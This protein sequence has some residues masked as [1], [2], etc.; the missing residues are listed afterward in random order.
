M[1]LAECQQLEKPETRILA[2][3]HVS[4]ENPKQSLNIEEIGVEAVGI[5]YRSLNHHSKLFVV[6]YKLGKMRPSA[7]GV[8]GMGQLRSG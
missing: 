6:P 7:A 3:L 5:A 8:G 1:P 4:P 2:V